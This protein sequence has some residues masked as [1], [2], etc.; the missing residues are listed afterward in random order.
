[1][2]SPKSEARNPKQ[3]LNSNIR[4]Y[5]IVSF[6]D[7]AFEHSVLFRHSTFDIRIYNINNEEDIY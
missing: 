2:I 3:I 7:F 5:Q 4:I 1:M 6:G